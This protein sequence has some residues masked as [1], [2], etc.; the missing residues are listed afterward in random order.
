M[1]LN[2]SSG[3]RT[4]SASLFTILSGGAVGSASA[5][6]VLGLV[7]P[8]SVALF[9]SAA[10]YLKSDFCAG[11]GGGY[12]YMLYLLTTPNETAV[13]GGLERMRQ[14]MTMLA[15][16]TALALMCRQLDGCVSVLYDTVPTSSVPLT[17]PMLE[18]LPAGSQGNIFDLASIAESLRAVEKPALNA[19]Y[20]RKKWM[21]LVAVAVTLII[22]VA[23]LLFAWVYSGSGAE[24]R[25]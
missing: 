17:D 24:L 15:N 22:G 19:T 7:T 10:Y 18:F 25:I 9:A 3:C 8:P 6:E 11:C 12:G 20:V 23:L 4:A 1:L 5:G 2:E 14:V 13:P 16:T 21:F